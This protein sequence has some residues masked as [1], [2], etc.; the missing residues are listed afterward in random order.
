VTTQMVSSV[1]AIELLKEGEGIAPTILAT[2]QG[3]RQGAR[4]I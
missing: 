4:T 3:D 2:E 1:M